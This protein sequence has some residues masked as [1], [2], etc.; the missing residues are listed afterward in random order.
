MQGKPDDQVGGG[1]FQV[2]VEVAA[3]PISDKTVRHG[4]LQQAAVVA[5]IELGGVIELG[6]RVDQI[7][8]V[9]DQWIVRSAIGSPPAARSIILATDAPNTRSILCVPV[10]N[11]DGRTIG[12]TQIDQL[13]CYCTTATCGAGMLD[14][15]A[16]GYLL[17]DCAFEEFATAVRAVAAGVAIEHSTTGETVAVP[18]DFVRRG[19]NHY[20]LR[21]RGNSMID[22]QIAD[23]DY[24]VV[25]K[26]PVAR[27]GQIVV[28]LTD[29]GDATLK[30]W[31]PEKDK[32]RIRL[33]P[34]NPSMKPIYVKNAKVF[35]VV[36]GVVRK[37]E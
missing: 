3:D 23:G 12:V 33:Q 1:T 8:R 24:V 30:R 20:V 2:I 31:F 11:K 14:A 7:E 27:K 26:Q 17:K 21:V 18:D 6:A 34:A 32:K 4:D 13:Q 28:A 36:V 25:R 5:V 35:G 10:I 15:G 29:D 16:S 19:G 9:N 37:V 22:D